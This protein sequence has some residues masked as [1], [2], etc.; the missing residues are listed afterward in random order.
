MTWVQ[1][2]TWAT[3]D[4]VVEAEAAFLHRYP[5]FDPSGAF[6]VLRHEEYGRL[7]AEQEVY[8]DYTGG[9]LHAAS[10][11]TAHAE[12]L[13]SQVF[14]NPH[15]NN[16][17]SLAATTYV[18]D[19]RRAVCEFFNAPMDDYWCIF[20][21]NASAALRLVGEAYRFVPRS[22]FALTVDN[23]NSVNGIREFARAKGA[24]VSYVPITAPDLRI[25]RLAVSAALR[26]R[27]DSAPNL[28]AFPAQSN[29]SGVQHDLDLVREA[30]ALGWHVLVDIAAF[31]PTNRFDV[32]TVRPDF[33]VLSL[34]KMFGYPTGIGCLLMRRDRYDDLARPWFA[35][36]T[37]TI[38][39]V[40]GDGHYLHRSESGFED[41]T[42]D[43]LNVPAVITGL[44]HLERIGRDAVHRRVSCLT[45]WLLDELTGLRH[46][47][48]RPL[49]RIH[50]P[51]TTDGRGGTIAF[52]VYDRDGAVIDDRRVEKL[53]NRA[54]ISLRTGCFC[55]P[56]ASETA[57]RL[58]P[59]QL[60][61]LFGRSE[62]ATYPELRDRLL[63]DLGRFVSAIRVSV[64]LA[65]NFADV[66]ALI[67]FLRRF[68]DRSADEITP[69]GREDVCL[70]TK[71]R[72]V[73]QPD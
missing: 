67:C 39:S 12:L 29:F 54:H 10:Q 9:G 4:A 60:R 59:E 73:P 3:A 7:D 58:T 26:H 42:V 72:R 2:A 40:G 15:S 14:G 69:V 36:G 17:T 5:E 68:V 16:P 70:S 25:D 37:I 48:G 50:G 45:D 41:G 55:N 27:D 49:V 51:V 21:A 56:G 57:H 22:T 66:F 35:G 43:Y 30:Q 20:T 18:D 44:R 52:T 1:V 47:S 31:A 13:R 62:P 34:Y 61:P 71:P 46:R 65:T 33:A 24:R 23:H 38:A 28:L 11:I 8:L 19:A 6:A 53:A 64:G 63:G 32:A